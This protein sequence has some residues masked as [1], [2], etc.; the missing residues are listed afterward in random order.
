MIEQESS[1]DS[2][3]QNMF[4]AQQFD[5][6]N[7]HESFPNIMD[8]F[9][10]PDINEPSPTANNEVVPTST[11]EISLPTTDK[12]APTIMDEVSLAP[13]NE[14]PSQDIGEV[15]TEPTSELLSTA[16]DEIPSKVTDETQ[17]ETAREDSLSTTNEVLQE[18]TGDIPPIPPTNET[19]IETINEV[20]LPDTNEVVV[21]DIS[22]EE[23]SKSISPIPDV[24]FSSDLP[25]LDDDPVLFSIENPQMPISDTEPQDYI[26][27]VPCSDDD[28]DDDFDNEEIHD[29]KPIS[30]TNDKDNK[31]VESLSS[32]NK[33][34]ASPLLH[35][36]LLTR[37]NLLF[38]V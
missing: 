1:N 6:T 16:T 25:P 8:E 35:N 20:L 34:F 2:E 28:D 31:T 24:S 10:T 30:I 17:F 19:A 7:I 15:I 13:M 33:S 14:T 36:P 26:I 29:H 12:S 22:N 11:N 38:V 23:N 32:P 21:S 37:G 27:I 3:V 9:L 18:T 5:D 4:D